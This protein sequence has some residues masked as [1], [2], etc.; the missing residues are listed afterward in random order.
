[1]AQ[2]QTSNGRRRIPGTDMTAMVDVA[3]L[4]LMFFVLTASVLKKPGAMELALPVGDGHKVNCSKIMTV[5]LLDNDQV[6]WTFGCEP[7]LEKTDLS[8]QG[9]RNSILTCNALTDDLIIV[10]K[11]TKLCRY[12]NLVDA[13]DEFRITGVKKYALTDPTDEDKTFLDTYK[14]NIE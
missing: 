9:L 10:L 12:E 8:A 11:P 7:V 3:F 5:Y 1:M 6:G 14:I 2:I 4:L 13:L